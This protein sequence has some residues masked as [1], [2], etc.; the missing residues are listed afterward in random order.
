M[1]INSFTVQGFRNLAQPVTFGPLDSYNLLHGP[2]GAGKSN[3][4]QA[5]D[6]FFRLLGTGNG[7]TKDARPTT[8]ENGEQVIGCHFRELF[9]I[10][11]P[12]PIQWE[13][14]VSI[15]AEELEEMSIEAEQPTDQVTIGAEMVPALGGQAQL[16]IVQFSLGD[17]DLAKLDPE[18]DGDVA[19]G[20]TVRGFVAGMLD[21][22]PT[23]RGS[24]FRRFDMRRPVHAAGSPPAPGDGL[25]P[26]AILDALFDARQSLDREQRARWNLFAR[27]SREMEVEL[28][29]GQFETAFDRKSGRASL[30][31][32]TAS[33]TYPLEWLGSGAQQMVALLACLALTRAKFVAIEEPEL[34]LSH[35]LQERLPD[36]LAMV[37][38]SGLC[39]GQFFIASQSRALDARGSSFVIAVGAQGPEL[40]KKAWEGA[41]AVPLA[42]SAPAV[43]AART[44]SAPPRPSSTP[45]PATGAAD[46]DLDG[47]I[48][49]VDQLSEL[50]PQELVVAPTAPASSARPTAAPTGGARPTAPADG[51]SKAP[52]TAATSAGKTGAG[53][54]PWKWQPGSNKPPARK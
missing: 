50:D 51:A 11:E 2:N 3:L 12:G 17:K 43:T 34:H 32:D 30:V 20:Q 16:R 53:E 46:G 31:Y 4:L 44:P 8:L 26:T 14:E 54:P 13:V 47:L 15:G 6:I 21:L 24:P 45:V 28:G 39:A 52:A 38:E 37:V 42:Q 49:L 33:A 27:M 7:I 22:D 18:K 36:L 23:R 35:R 19:F 10:A 9:N 41:P 48:G 5:M 25:V 29:P 1:K 40:T